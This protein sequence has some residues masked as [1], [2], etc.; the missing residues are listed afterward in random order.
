MIITSSTI[1]LIDYSTGF[2]RC[3]S[4]PLN[5]LEKTQK[6]CYEVPYQQWYCF[7]VD[8]LKFLYSSSVSCSKSSSFLRFID[9]ILLGGTLTSNICP[10]VC[11][12]IWKLMCFVLSGTSRPIFSDGL[13]N[14]TKT[15]NFKV[16]CTTWK[17]P[18]AVTLS[19]TLLY[20]LWRF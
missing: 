11:Q 1:N 20:L 13:Y 15:H 4:C 6:A 2:T 5:A 19:V 9:A 12:D 8:S 16:Q 14:F 18:W 7:P 3:V 17:K 10:R